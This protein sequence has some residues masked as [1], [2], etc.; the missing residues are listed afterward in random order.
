MSD[1][2]EDPDPM[3]FVFGS[4]PLFD[5]ILPATTDI[6]LSSRAKYLNQNQNFKFDK[7]FYVGTV[8]PRSLVHFYIG[9]RYILKRLLKHTLTGQNIFFN[10]MVYKLV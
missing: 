7:T 9:T 2:G 3:I 4:N 1:I 5:G 6:L 8:C 10:H